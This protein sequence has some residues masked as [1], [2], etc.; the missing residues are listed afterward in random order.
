MVKCNALK[1]FDGEQNSYIVLMRAGDLIQTAIVDT[2]D[3]KTNTKGYQRDIN[4]TRANR[5][6]NYL[7][8]C[9]GQFDTACLLNARDAKGIVFKSHKKSLFGTLSINTKLHIID[10]QHRIKG[11]EVAIKKKRFDNERM[12]PT[13]ITIG[14]ERRDEALIFLIVNRTAKGIRADLT[15]ELIFKTIDQKRLTKNLRSVL[16]LTVKMEIGKFVNII[17]EKLNNDKR[18]IWFERMVAANEKTVGIKTVIKRTFSQSLIRA[19]N[20]CGKLKR[21]ANIGEEETVLNWVID[22]WQAIAEICGIATSHTKWQEY[23]LMR[24]VGVQ[25][26]NRLFARILD[27]VGEDAEKV[28]FVNALSK[29]P[30]FDD[31]AWHLKK[32]ELGKA[33]TNM[34]AIN[35]IYDKLE[36]ELDTSFI[37]K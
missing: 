21:A 2:Y 33:G 17:T 24:T 37:S 14:K 11:L 16:G 8:E 9:K 34:S 31:E 6:A 1:F 19:I 36:M 35:Y 13:I 3:S 7:V 15:D 4:A 5:F 23:A 29:M 27:D 30:S 12:V 18:S 10:G 25:V 20:S 22:Y 26:M 32:G 28:D